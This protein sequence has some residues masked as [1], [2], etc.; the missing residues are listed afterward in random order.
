MRG[1]RGGHFDGLAGEGRVIYRGVD[2]VRGD[3]RQIA[4]H[5]AAIFRTDK[6]HHRLAV[7]GGDK[8]FDLRAVLIA[9]LHG[10]DVRVGNVGAFGQNG[11]DARGNG[12]VGI[13]DGVVEVG[14]ILGQLGRFHF[15]EGD[16]IGVFRDV[17]HG[18]QRPG[19]IRQFDKPLLFKQLQGAGFVGRVV[20]DGDG[21]TGARAT[22]KGREGKQK[23]GADQRGGKNFFHDRSPL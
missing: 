8:R 1:G 18:G 16:I 17:V 2:A 14:E 11:G 23:Q 20:R 4:H 22:G 19:V 15:A 3:V 9:G 21:D 5:G 10:Q 12:V 7:H 6:I 13:D